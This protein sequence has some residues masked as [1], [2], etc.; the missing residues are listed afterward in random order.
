[1]VAITGCAYGA[2]PCRFSSKCSHRSARGR[3]HV[4]DPAVGL[5]NGEA[6]EGDVDQHGAGRPA[7]CLGRE[8][9]GEGKVP[10]GPGADLSVQDEAG[11]QRAGEVCGEGGKVGREIAV[12]SRL[13]DRAVALGEGQ[14]AEA[15]H[16]E[17]VLDGAGSGVFVRWQVP[18]GLG[19][20]DIDGWAKSCGIGG[21]SASLPQLP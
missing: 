11:G 18:D 20:H 17:R 19:A 21:H 5:G 7:P 2:V 10:V 4:P 1:V 6:V 14:G 15:V 3:F 12:G 16:L 9:F 8:Q 13:E